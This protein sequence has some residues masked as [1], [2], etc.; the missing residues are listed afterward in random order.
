MSVTQRIKTE[1][2]LPY[3]PR[4]LKNLALLASSFSGDYSK[5]RGGFVDSRPE[6]SA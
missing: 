2:A 5:I 1:F 4:D 3:F 6:G